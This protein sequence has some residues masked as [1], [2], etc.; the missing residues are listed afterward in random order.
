MREYSCKS[1][2]YG[3][4]IFERFHSRC[5]QVYMHNIVILVSNYCFHILNG[6]PLYK[7]YGISVD[8]RYFPSLALHNSTVQ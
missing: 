8:S 5:L 7:S 2:R 6:K 4:V 3:H 1:L